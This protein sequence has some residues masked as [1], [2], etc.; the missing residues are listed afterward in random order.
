[1][2]VAFDQH[3]LVLAWSSRH[4]ANRLGRPDDIADFSRSIDSR[5]KR[6]GHL[7]AAADNDGCFW[8][9]PSGCRESPC[10]LADDAGGRGELWQHS[11][12]YARG[13][14]NRLG[15]GA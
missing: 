10:D 15:P 1:M 3:G 11:R 5:A 14:E 2:R 8:R 4:S 13:I 9:K 7:V 12:V 6:G